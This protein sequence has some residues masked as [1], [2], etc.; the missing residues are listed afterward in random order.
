MPINSELLERSIQ[1]CYSDFLSYF[2][3]IKNFT[4]YSL[5]FWEEKVDW[6]EIVKIEAES[7]LLYNKNIL[8]IEW[9]CTKNTPSNVKLRFFLALFLSVKDLERCGDYLYSI[10]K[11]ATK[12]GNSDLKKIILHSQLWE[13]VSEYC[14]SIYNL[15]G[16][17]SGEIEQFSYEEILSQKSVLHSKLSKISIQ[18]NERLLKFTGI[19]PF[20]SYQTPWRDEEE[21][22]ERIKNIIALSGLLQLILVKIDRFLDHVFNI[23]E[24]F[25]YIKNQEMQLH[26]SSLLKESHRPD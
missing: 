7:N 23:V 12:D 9:Q 24:N 20:T 4:R 17:S 25:Y 21:H 18:L 14:Q 6:S 8:E 10:A 19:E 1:K 16:K 11:I 3:L 22:S 5:L 13:I 15:F 26:L 2:Q